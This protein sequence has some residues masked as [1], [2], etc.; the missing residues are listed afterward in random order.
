VREGIL[1]LAGP[2]DDPSSSDAGW[3]VALWDGKNAGLKVAEP[4]LLARLD[5]SDVK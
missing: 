1:I 2:D 5:L 3:V 4:K